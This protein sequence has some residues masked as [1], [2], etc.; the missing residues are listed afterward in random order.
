MG[1]VV[2]SRLLFPLL[3]SQVVALSS[4]EV[5]LYCFFPDNLIFPL[6]SPVF[7]CLKQEQSLN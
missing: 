3:V 4:V 1:I 6:L 2:L 7:V 5:S